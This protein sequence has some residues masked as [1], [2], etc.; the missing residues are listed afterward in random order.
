VVPA[1][2]QIQSDSL[3]DDIAPCWTRVQGPSFSAEAS[4]LE[5]NIEAVNKH[6]EDSGTVSFEKFKHSVHVE[7]GVEWTTSYNDKKYFMGLSH[8]G[9]AIDWR[10]IDYGF[11]CGNDGYL[12]VYEKGVGRTTV[13]YKEGDKLAIKIKDEGVT[14]FHNRKVIYSS[15]TV[16]KKEFALVVDSSFCDAGAKAHSIIMTLAKEAMPTMQGGGGPLGWNTLSQKGNHKGD[17]RGSLA[18]GYRKPPSSKYIGVTWCKSKKK[19]KAQ[20]GH[21]GKTCMQY[22]YIYSIDWARG[23]SI[24]MYAQTHPATCTTAYICIIKHTLRQVR[25]TLLATL[26]MRR[27]RPRRTTRLLAGLLVRTN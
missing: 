7:Q 11:G 8:Q 17:V 9:G 14:Y 24:Y 20:I 3:N 13:T 23:Y 5:K 1:M 12:D 25:T 10:T 6:A 27:R 22:L 15:T 26:T 4:T 16:C 19:W 21:G 18:S 2:Q